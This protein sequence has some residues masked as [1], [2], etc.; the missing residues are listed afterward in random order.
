MG[1]ITAMEMCEGEPPLMHMKP[2]R[3]MYIIST[4]GTPTLK[5]PD[6]WSRALK[7]FLSRAL[8]LQPQMR[9]SVQ[10]L[11]MH[12]FIR[13]AS[14]QKEFAAFVRASVRPDSKKD[15]KK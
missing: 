10:H 14:T 1:G 4:G 8:T 12:P 3:A 13:K 5:Q 6:K 7:H 15:S 9:S 2:L 11:L